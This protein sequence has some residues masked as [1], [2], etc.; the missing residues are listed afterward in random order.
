MQ[1]RRE[2]YP[3]V[4]LCH[5]G[6]T[7]TSQH[8]NNKRFTQPYFSIASFTGTITTRGGLTPTLLMS[9]P[10]FQEAKHLD[11]NHTQCFGAN[12][13][14]KPLLC[15]LNLNFHLRE[16]AHSTCLLFLCSFIQRTSSPPTHSSA[17]LQ[18]CCLARPE[19]L[20]PW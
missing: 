8:G 18:N 2:S 13:E 1:E 11:Y 6:L 4:L 14:P 12:L 17:C 9:K 10:G 16:S 3:R 5:F 15:P 7:I 19:D 20:L